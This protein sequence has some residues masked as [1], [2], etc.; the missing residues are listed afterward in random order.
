[1]HK[2]RTE[3]FYFNPREHPYTKTSKNRLVMAVRAQFENSNEY[4]ILV[5]PLLVDPYPAIV[6]QTFGRGET[7]DTDVEYG[8]RND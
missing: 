8:T 7:E 1:L 3:I 6:A 5:L 4:V 2:F